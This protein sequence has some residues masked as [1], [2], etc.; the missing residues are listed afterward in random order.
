MAFKDIGKALA[1]LR[2]QRGLTQAQLADRCGMGR[3]QVSRYESGKE[4]MKL[5]T[6]EKILRTLTVEPDDFFRYLR[7]LDGSDSL[8]Q[9]RT[10][11]RIDDRMLADAFRDLH[12]AI[13][14]LHEV[15]ERVVDRD[16]RYAAF[17]NLHAAID[18]LRQVVERAVEPGVRFARL[19]E[20]AA[21]PGGSRTVGHG[22]EP[23][24][25][26]VRS[27]L[28]GR[29]EAVAVPTRARARADR[30]SALSEVDGLE[31]LLARLADMTGEVE[32]VLAHQRS[33][34]LGFQG[35]EQPAGG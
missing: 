17:Q 24:E 32:A 4:L 15:V 18:G 9:G 29:L 2:Q 35:G 31:G 10:G 25:A 8:R 21:G 11:D 5:E 30:S 12:G 3:P 1:L 19:L 6:L 22:S 7:S 16:A 27:P 34:R 28:P 13:D 23:R 14:G 33:A 26:E 20:E